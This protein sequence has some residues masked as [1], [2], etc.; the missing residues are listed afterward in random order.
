MAK[1]ERLDLR[2]SSHQKRLL[3]QAANLKGE[4]VSEFVLSSAMASA[5][6]ALLDQRVFLLDSEAFDQLVSRS[7]DVVKNKAAI[8][9]ILAI[10][11]PWQD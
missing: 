9:K 3:Q 1:N 2:V 8:D 4:T 7:E 6:E 5:D 11:T 10:K